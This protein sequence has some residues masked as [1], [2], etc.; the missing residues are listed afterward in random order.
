MNEEFDEGDY[1][2]EEDESEKL[3]LSFGEDGNAKIEKESDYVQVRAKDF[4]L[5]RKFIEG[6]GKEAFNSFLKK[7]EELTK[8]IKGE[9]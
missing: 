8:K 2:D 9:K 5:I 7:E 6:E 3:I 1:E 4:E